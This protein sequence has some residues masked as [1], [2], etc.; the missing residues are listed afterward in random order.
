MTEKS[1]LIS[2]F[3]LRFVQSE[4]NGEPLIFRGSIRHIQADRRDQLYTLE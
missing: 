3:I 1:L 4:Q 2:S